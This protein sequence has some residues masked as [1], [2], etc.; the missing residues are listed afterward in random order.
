MGIP[1]KGGGLGHHFARCTTAA[2]FSCVFAGSLHAQQRPDAGTILREQP[3]PAPALPG[4]PAP[5]KPAAPEAQPPDSGARV[6]VNAFRIEGATLFR[7][8][9]LKALVADLVGKELS[10][11][12]LQQGA[13]RITAHY[14]TNGYLARV[15]VPQQDVKAGVVTY[16][17]V[18]GRLG[19]VRI[20]GPEGRL[21]KARAKRFIE[22]RQRPGERLV[23]GDVSEALEILNEQPGVG[24]RSTL[25]PGTA[26]GQVDMVV[27]VVDRPL[28][29]WTV[30]ANNAGPR[31]TGEAQGG[32]NLTLNNPSGHLDAAALLLNVSDGTKYVRGDYGIALGDRG[33]R[34]GVSASYLDYRLT[35]DI[36][37]ALQ[38]RG[39]AK[40]AGA[41]LTYPLMRSNEL[42]LTAAGGYEYRLLRDSTVAG[43][44][45]NRVV[46][47][48]NAG[49]SGFHFDEFL[50]G[51]ATL[52]GVTLT[53][54]DTDQRNVAARAAD[55]A[56]RQ[57]QGSFLKLSYN[58]G[59]EQPLDQNWTFFARL[60]GQVTDKNIDSSE[61]MS[62]GG[63]QGI[64]AYP[65]GEATGDQ[66]WLASFSLAR[67]VHRTLDG[68]LFLDVG[69]IQ[70]NKNEFAGFNAGN[71]GL[72][73]RY[74]IAGFGAGLD[75]RLGSQFA[76]SF[77][78]ARRIGVNPGVDAQGNDA[79]GRQSKWRGWIN[80]ALRF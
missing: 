43:E 14:A 25:V 15:L 77:S 57:T 78:I 11:A 48:L 19:G 31:G 67:P 12:D 2:I 20:E 22:S 80:A 38:A 56:G 3:K 21:D 59:R 52:F 76:L 37:N 51:G 13:A 68:N 53:G 66:G 41:A 9:D 54:G 33:L 71:P 61:R 65:V 28:T 32:V 60:R 30:T 16:R 49:V 44:V 35:Q 17:V 29:S 64:R 7:E 63:P 8:E 5:V 47:S 50:G 58:L 74:E 34:L 23:L 75:W 45:G 39:D 42:N 26:E 62:L 18:E 79:D 70:L 24:A 27:N 73:N 40:T 36:F 46:H 10:F 72:R 1:D 55:L 6:R 4:K 69:G